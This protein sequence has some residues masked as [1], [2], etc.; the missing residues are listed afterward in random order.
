MTSFATEK[1]GRPRGIRGG[2]KKKTM[3]NDFVDCCRAPTQFTGRRGGKKVMEKRKKRR[4]GTSELLGRGGGERER[5]RQGIQR[6]ML[7]RRNNEKLLNKR[8]DKVDETSAVKLWLK[9]GGG[10]VT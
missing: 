10:R 5:G 3:V 8:W 2:L 9:A 6:Q 4:E 7:V 1:K